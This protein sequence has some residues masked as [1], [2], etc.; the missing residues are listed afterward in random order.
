[1]SVAETYDLPPVT[2]RKTFFERKAVRRAL[3]WFVII[4]MFV[5]WE[6]VVRLFAIQEFVLPAPSAI[7]KSMWQWREPIAINAFHTHN[8]TLIGYEI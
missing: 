1:M 3:P 6:I 2:R 8:T 4:A 7:F 5:I